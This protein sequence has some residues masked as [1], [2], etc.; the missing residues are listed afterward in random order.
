MTTST[1]RGCVYF[2]ASVETTTSCSYTNELLRKDL[3]SDDSTLEE[4]AD[5]AEADRIEIDECLDTVEWGWMVFVIG[6]PVVTA[7]VFVAGYAV[8][9]LMERLSFVCFCFS[10]NRS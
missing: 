3:T 4:L 7:L 10:I 1:E 5:I 8:F 9:S 6:I 2:S